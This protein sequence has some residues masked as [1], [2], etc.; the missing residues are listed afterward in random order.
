MKQN[1][2]SSSGCKVYAILFLLLFVCLQVCHADFLVHLKDGTT[3]KVTKIEFRGE[4]TYLF[5]SNGMTTS[6]LTDAIDYRNMGLKR[7][8]FPYGFSNDGVTVHKIEPI[9]VKTGPSQ[10][11]LR[12]Q[13]NAASQTAVAVRPAG[14]IGKGQTVRI[15]QTG[16]RSTTVIVRD[17]TT[18]NFRRILLSDE[19]FQENFELRTIKKA[20]AKSRVKKVE[21]AEESKEPE[22]IRVVSDPVKQVP[23]APKPTPPS[24]WI[25]LGMSIGLLAVG[26]ASTILLSSTQRRKRAKKVTRESRPRT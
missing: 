26:F 14:S 15:I 25:P 23:V 13:W 9:E 8:D 17:E 6:V 10:D 12:A 7:P 3:K 19:I 4:K 11:E 2:N 16:P 22:P 20:D 18:K 24:A 21:P 1:L 5:L